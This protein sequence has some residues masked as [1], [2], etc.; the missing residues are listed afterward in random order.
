MTTHHSF[1]NNPFEIKSQD[2]NWDKDIPQSV[3]YDDRFFQ[4]N[5]IAEIYNVFIKPNDIE[6][7]W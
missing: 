1:F 3:E 7:R 4:T 2:V 5:T 6:D